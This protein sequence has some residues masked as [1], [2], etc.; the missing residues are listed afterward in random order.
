MGPS[1]LRYPPAHKEVASPDWVSE[2]CSLL[3]TGVADVD[4]WERGWDLFLTECDEK[5]KAQRHLETADWGNEWG[6]ITG[7]SVGR[8]ASGRGG[9]GG[10]GGGSGGGSGGGTRGG[11]G[12]AGGP[13]GNGRGGKQTARTGRSWTSGRQVDIP[14]HPPTTNK[15]RST[16]SFDLTPT[17]TST[18]KS[19]K[20]C[21]ILEKMLVHVRNG[22]PNLKISVKFYEPTPGD[23]REPMSQALMQLLNYEGYKQLPPA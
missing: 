8:C 19:T 10:N 12:G 22:N 14:S 1:P 5:V 3:S 13:S 21:P 6:G 11:C 9:Q 4:T 17:K 18:F 15:A 20:S 2:Y 16:A 23:E 7:D